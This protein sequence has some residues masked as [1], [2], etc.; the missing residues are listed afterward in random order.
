VT[1]TLDVRSLRAA[2]AAGLVQR[3]DPITGQVTEP[4]PAV[5]LGESRRAAI[6]RI[7]AHDAAWVLTD[8]RVTGLLLGAGKP[9]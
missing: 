6:A 9:D 8:G 4:L 2:E 5:G 3:E 1:G 7:G